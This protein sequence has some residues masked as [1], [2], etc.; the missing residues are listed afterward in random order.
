M[1]II[2]DG[3]DDAYQNWLTENPRG[4]VMNARRNMAPSYRV[5]HRAFCSS[6]RN[7][8]AQKC[9]GAFTQRSYIKICAPDVDDLRDW[10]RRN[11][12][13]NGTFSK[14][15]SRCNS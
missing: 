14:E 3:N 6:I 2:F 13:P 15:C 11:G 4:Y 5:L 9:Q 1:P 7:Y 12:R 8:S 10:L